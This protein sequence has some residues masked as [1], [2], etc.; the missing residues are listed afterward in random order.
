MMAYNDA[1]LL[2]LIVFFCC[3]PAVLLLRKPKGARVAV[4]AH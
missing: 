2:I 3:A 4:D 1:W